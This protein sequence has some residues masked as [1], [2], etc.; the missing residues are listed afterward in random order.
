MNGK[1]FQGI[2][3]QLGVVPTAEMYEAMQIVAVRTAKEII[4]NK[5]QIKNKDI[6]VLPE[7]ASLFITMFDHVSEKVQQIA[8]SKGFHTGYRNDGQSI[9][10]MHSELSEALEYMRHGNPKSDHIPEISGVEEELADVII[11]IM[12]YAVTRKL[13]VA[14]ALI[15]KM[16]FNIT[17]QHIHE[18]KLF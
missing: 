16:N 6:V 4:E 13:K 7:D 11:R 17:R 8:A 3:E 18:G 15:A 5:P 9:A 2:I 10:L 14:D 1:D 12:D